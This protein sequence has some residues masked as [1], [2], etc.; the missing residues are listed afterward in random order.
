MHAHTACVRNVPQSSSLQ[1]A[2]PPLPRRGAD[3]QSFRGIC[4][5][6]ATIALIGVV[7]AVATVA[8]VAVVAAVVDAAGV[9]VVDA[10]VDAAG[11][12]SAATV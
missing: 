12:E 3:T 4:G 6:E 11:V 7:V 10:V 5:M 2:C 9:A 8:G 1:A